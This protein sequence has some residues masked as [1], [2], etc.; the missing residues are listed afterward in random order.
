MEYIYL[1]DMVWQRQDMK[2]GFGMQ[3]GEKKFEYGSIVVDVSEENGCFHFT[4]KKT[5]NRYHNHYAWAFAENT[6]DN[7]IEI[8]KLIETNKELDILNRRSKAIH[9]NITTLKNN[10]ISIKRERR[11]KI[12]NDK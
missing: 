8:N 1:L 9:K 11:I 7:V 5:G 6:P 2:K 3:T 10:D 4:D 12:L